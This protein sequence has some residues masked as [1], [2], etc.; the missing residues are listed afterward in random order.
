MEKDCSPGKRLVVV[1]IGILIL[2]AALAFRL[3][4]I[5]V[6]EGPIYAA[7]ARTQQRIA[8]SGVDSRGEICDRNG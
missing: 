8:L 3:Y 7:M 6:I 5:Q 4:Q 1:F 2:M